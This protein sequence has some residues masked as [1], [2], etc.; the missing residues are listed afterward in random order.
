MVSENK[1]IQKTR[2]DTS[3]SSLFACLGPYQP[4]SAKS[5]LGEGSEVAYHWVCDGI[6]HST[7]KEYHQNIHWV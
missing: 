4:E 3:L 6:P 5:C 1:E 2:C 7:R